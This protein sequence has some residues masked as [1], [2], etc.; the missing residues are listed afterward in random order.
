MRQRSNGCRW[1]MPPSL[2]PSAAPRR[3]SARRHTGP[4][5]RGRPRETCEQFCTDSRYLRA[6]TF[7]IKHHWAG[8]TE[9]CH[10]RRATLPLERG[11]VPIGGQKF[12]PSLRVS[13]MPF[14]QYQIDPA[15]IEAMRSAFKTA[16]E[17]LMLRCD[18]D[19]PMTG[20]I[21]A[22]IV[23]LAKTGEHDADRL[24]SY[25][26]ADLEGRTNAA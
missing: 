5:G 10:E 23:A 15:H 22:K 24:A 18:K 14:S 26:L 17:A 12:P 3:G 8:A 9:S 11:R 25:V 4:V 7:G 16:C 21:V 1:W 20:V 19:D 2:P 6:H 13:A